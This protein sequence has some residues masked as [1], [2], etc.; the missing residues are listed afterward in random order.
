MIDKLF[1][2]VGTLKAGLDA[3]WLR[4]EVISNNIANVDTP[5]YKSSSVSFESAFKKALAQDGNGNKQTR[6]GHIEFSNA[7]A[8]PTVIKDTNTTYRMDGNNVNIDAEN[9]ELAKNQIYYSTLVQ[10]LS[11]EFRK[12]SMAINEGK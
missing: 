1:G 3:A 2:N 11:S 9:A 5:N 6:E 10:Q 7:T 4:N 8:Q 12:L